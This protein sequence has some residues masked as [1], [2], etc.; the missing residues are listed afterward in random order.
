MGNH[1]FYARAYDKAGN[2]IESNK[3]RV[4]VRPRLPEDSP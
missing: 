1:T 2:V 4:A 3:V